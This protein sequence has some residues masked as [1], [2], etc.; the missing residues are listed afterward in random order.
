MTTA[1]ERDDVQTIPAAGPARP[2]RLR[3][4]LRRPRRPKP[5]GDPRVKALTRF[6]VSISVFTFLGHLVLGFEQAPITPLVCLAV[7]YA[8]ALTFETVDAWT[9]HRR[10]EW[11]G[12]PRNLAVFLLPPHISAL[13]CAMLLYA[14]NDLWPYVFAVIVANGS[15]YVFRVRQK[16]RLKHVLNP[17]NTGIAATLLLFHRWVGIAP[18]YH[19]TNNFHGVVAWAVPIGILFAGTMLNA[20]LTRKMPLITTWVGC[21]VLQAVARW[22]WHGDTLTAALLPLTG[23]AFILFTNYMITDP[24]STPFSARGQRVFGA[25]TAFVYGALVWNGVVFGLFLALVITCLLRGFVLLAAPFVRDAWWARRRLSPP[26][27]GRPEAIDKA[28]V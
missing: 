17:S 8:S 5:P 13:A 24:G 11:L 7:S 15:K 19:F 26:A 14:G 12:G 2:G 18:P 22:L 10:I 28:A 27:S 1:R 20:K 4:P 25:T 9:W 21:F 3:P 16:G 23:I 6:A